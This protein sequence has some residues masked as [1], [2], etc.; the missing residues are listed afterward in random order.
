M[1]SLSVGGAP[2]HTAGGRPI[3]FALAPPESATLGAVFR[4]I[5]TA[6]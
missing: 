6:H 3:F 4:M 2:L 5:E 1:S